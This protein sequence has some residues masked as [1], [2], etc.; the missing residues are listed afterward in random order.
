MLL[1]DELKSDLKVIEEKEREIT[2]TKTEQEHERQSLE[3]NR[4][5]LQVLFDESEKLLGELQS[6]EK[7][8]KDKIDQNDAQIKALDAQIKKYY[9]EQKRLEE[10]RR[11]EAE[12]KNQPYVPVNPVHNG[13]FIWPL[14]GYSKIT[15]D[16]YDTADR[17]HMHGAI[18]IAGAG[19]YGAR[20]VASAPGT[21]IH[22]GW[23]GGYGNC[24]IIDHG[25]GVSTRYGHMSTVAVSKGQKV[26]QGQ[27]IG[28]VGSTGNST[29]PHLHFEYRVNE[30]IHNPHEIV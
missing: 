25:N 2:K 9:E 30:K 22:A 24:V 29:G 27:T 19:V 12:A 23:Y 14:P 3:K 11:K 13:K 21:I 17:S 16:F 20:I 10:Q 26:S 6:E 18:D 1:I 15:S 28:N 5:D 7:K 4:A 8:A